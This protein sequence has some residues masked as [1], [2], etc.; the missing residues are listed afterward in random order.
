MHYDLRLLTVEDLPASWEMSRIAFG[1]D[2][3]PPPGWLSARPGRHTW[4]AFDGA[5]R[6]VAKAMDREQDH[7]FGGRRVPASGIAGVVVM[8][9]LRGTGLSRLVLARLF[10]ASRDRGAV[11]ATLFRTNPG[12]YR[13]LGCEQIGNLTWTALPT[14]SLAEVRRP[15]EVALRPAEVAD[16]PA[17]LETYRIVARA[18]AGLMER[19]GPLFDT[20][21]GAVL[22]G[23]DGIT[24]A[25]DSAGSVQGYVSW[26]RGPGYD[27]S[28]R[29]SV[30]DL[31]GLSAPAT[32]AMLALLG[33]W[34]SVAPTVVLRLPDPDPAALLS[35]FTGARVESDDRWM[36]RVLDAAGAVAARGWPRH[37]NGSVDLLLADGVCPWNAGPQRLI[38][39]DGVGRLEPGGRGELHLD[40]RGLALIYAGIGAPALLRRAGLLGGDSTDGETFLQA[41]A[42][43]PP[44]ALL[45]YF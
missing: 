33:S 36:L 37:V 29:L 13:R 41:A 43:G 23:H 10:A 32:T 22:A 39:A 4:G 14:A 42:A 2:R 8:P 18:G 44:P 16:V 26:K 1:L 35:S 6:L 7:W 24:V 11:I 28:S 5:G 19:S 38:L 15:M 9:D 25:T 40:I 31:I 34:A 3:K 21:P 12:P 45:D 27:A 17:I 30:P 20:S